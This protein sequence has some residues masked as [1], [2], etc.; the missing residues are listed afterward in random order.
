MEK[1]CIVERNCED[2]YR[3]F[4]EAKRTGGDDRIAAARQDLMRALNLARE[5]SP[6]VYSE[7]IKRL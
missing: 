1:K 3:H 5:V 2:A 4:E 7:Y 6:E